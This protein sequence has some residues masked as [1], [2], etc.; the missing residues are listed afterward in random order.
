MNSDDE[1]GYGKPPKKHQFQKGRSGNPGGRPKKYKSPIS[2]LREPVK[3][4]VNGR[5]LEVT[6]FEAAVR[7]TAQGAI[8]GRVRAIKRFIRYCDLCNMIEELD[9]FKPAGVVVISHDYDGKK[10]IHELAREQHIERKMNAPKKQ[11]P[12]QL[13]VIRKV[14]LEKHLIPALGKRLAILELVLLKLKERALRDRDEAALE[15]FERLE[16]RR[17]PD[18]NAYSMGYLLVPEVRTLETTPLKVSRVEDDESI[19][20]GPSGK[21]DKT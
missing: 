15:L 8:E 14:A 18:I 16:L 20:I 5:T 2:V 1:V 10:T 4:S 17:M 19:E 12:E 6:A 11:L 13:E 3:M 9:D 7:T 21:R